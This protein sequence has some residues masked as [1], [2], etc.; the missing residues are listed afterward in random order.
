MSVPTQPGPAQQVIDADIDP[1]LETLVS[2]AQEQ[3]YSL[4]LVLN[5]RGLVI[6]GTLVGRDAW[7]DLLH[8]A[9]STAGAGGEALGRGLRD[10]MRGDDE[11][12]DQTAVRY[13]YIHL[14]DARVVSHDGHLPGRDGLLWRGRLGSVDAWSLGTLV[15]STN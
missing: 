1:V 12:E 10:G 11:P 3:G 7:F 4:G 6:T 9:A 8:E 14:K 15:T 5:V 13:G 2:L